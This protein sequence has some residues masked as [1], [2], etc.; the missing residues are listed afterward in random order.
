MK[1]ISKRA[2]NKQKEFKNKIVIKAL[3]KV[4]KGP[5]DDTRNKQIYSVISSLGKT[6]RIK[7]MI[8]LLKKVV[9]RNY[10]QGKTTNA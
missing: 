8:F 1:N 2:K 4:F 7:L 9:N 3:I 10:F 6:K 5:Q